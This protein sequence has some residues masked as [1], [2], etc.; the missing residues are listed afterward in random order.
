LTA[1]QIGDLT[2]HF[3]ESVPL[4]KVGGLRQLRDAVEEM[5]QSGVLSAEEAGFVELEAI[6]GFWTG[7]IGRRILA[8]TEQVHRELPFTMRLLPEDLRRLEICPQADELEGER[9]VGRG[10]VDLAVIRPNE[11][12]ILDFKTDHV[13]EADLPEKV[14]PY[15]KQLKLYGLALSRIYRRPVTERW[16]HF[17]ALGKTVRVN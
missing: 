14:V 17:L 11:I 12:W 1:A 10:K 7:E 8:S 5:V 9:F 16:L 15:G 13:G 4:D 2:H 3:L 6:A